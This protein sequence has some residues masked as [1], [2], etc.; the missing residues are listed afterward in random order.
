M[1]EE[2]NDDIIAKACELSPDDNNNA[3]EL[4][5]NGNVYEMI[6]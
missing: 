6:K 5:L 3:I 4:L 1:G 2:F